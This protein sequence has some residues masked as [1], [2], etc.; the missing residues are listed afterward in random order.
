[1]G[2]G[3]SSPEVERLDNTIGADLIVVG[4]VV[5]TGVLP[6]GPTLTSPQRDQLWR[7]LTSSQCSAMT[8]RFAPPRTIVR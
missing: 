5:L 8:W 1:M 3:F 6:F 7:L 4:D 2:N